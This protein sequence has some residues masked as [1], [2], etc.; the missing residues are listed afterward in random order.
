MGQ[1]VAGNQMTI[2]DLTDGYSIMLSQESHVW[3][4]NTFGVYPEN[5]TVE[6]TLSA[7]QGARAV[8]CNITGLLLCPPGITAKVDTSEATMYPKVTFTATS[9]C[10]DPGYVDIPISIDR[11]KVTITKRFTYSIAK[12]GEAGKDAV[13]IV[14]ES[15]NG[16]YFKN[17]SIS[18]ILTVN[19]LVGDQIITDMNALRNKFGANAK[20][21]WKQKRPGNSDFTDV[22]DTDP[23]L[24]ADGFLFTISPDDFLT[25]AVFNCVLDA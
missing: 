10:T 7:F 25:Q 3:A 17:T 6:I 9:E 22:P 20:L 13:T 24:S 1:R 5:Q 18:T 11:G 12:T 14:I 21:I 2:I 23:R 15:T 8:P 19:V 16:T 4:G